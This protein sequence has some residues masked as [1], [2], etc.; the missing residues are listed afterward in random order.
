MVAIGYSSI[1]RNAFIGAITIARA[2]EPA[3]LRK[4]IRAVWF[5]SENW[6]GIIVAFLLAAFPICDVGVLPGGPVAVEVPETLNFSPSTGHTVVLYPIFEFNDFD[7]AFHPILMSVSVLL[8]RLLYRILHLLPEGRAHYPHARL[9]YLLISKPSVYFRVITLLG[10]RRAIEAYSFTGRNLPA[11]R[12]L[13]A[14]PPRSSWAHSTQARCCIV[15]KSGSAEARS[16]FTR[17]TT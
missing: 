4:S 10:C 1:I 3:V 14:A 12:D 17:V 5:P 8:P 16:G 9:C 11:T 7:R 13:R 2:A 15:L 6:R